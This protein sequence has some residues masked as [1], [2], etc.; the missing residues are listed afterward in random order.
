[1]RPSRGR[2]V[3][4]WLTFWDS[5]CF[6]LSRY[7]RT[8][9]LSERSCGRLFRNLSSWFYHS[10]VVANCQGGLCRTIRK[11]YP[12]YKRCYKWIGEGWVWSLPT[13]VFLTAAYPKKIGVKLEPMGCFW[14]ATLD[15]F[16]ALAVH[17]LPVEKDWCQNS[18]RTRRFSNPTNWLLKV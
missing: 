2:T 1:M 5:H 9:N 13:F 11:L 18:K 8:F 14:S 17:R 15:T 3:F 16:S 10:E 6:S 12:N 4:S 7:F